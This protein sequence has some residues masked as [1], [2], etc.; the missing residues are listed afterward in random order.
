MGRWVIELNMM[1]TKSFV[2]AVAWL[3]AFTLCLPH[4]ARAQHPCDAAGDVGWRVL[5]SSEIVGV[6][7]SAPFRFSGDWVV[8][9][10]TTLLPLC[11]YFN[12]VGNYSLR[13]Y[14]L[15]PVEKKE[16]VVLCRASEAGLGVPVPPYAGTCPPR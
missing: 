11:N 1:A 16:R 6:K 3:A 14:S 2:I 4:S 9:R 12:A 13:S 7:D 5:A 15:D 10:T 8:E